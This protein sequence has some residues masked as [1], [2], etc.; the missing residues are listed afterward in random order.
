MQN[1]ADNSLTIKNKTMKSLI[2]KLFG[3]K[4]GGSEGFGGLVD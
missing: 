1:A 2:K 3:C 4:C